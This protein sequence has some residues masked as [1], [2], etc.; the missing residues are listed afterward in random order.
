M[1]RTR[2]ERIE[3]KLRAKERRQ[4]AR[5]EQRK[6]GESRKHRHGVCDSLKATDVKP[7]RSKARMLADI[8]QEE[9]TSY[10]EIYGRGVL[11]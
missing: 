8:E 9:L 3:L 4:E 6:R 10:A 2:E 1:E 11:K 5:E 7:R